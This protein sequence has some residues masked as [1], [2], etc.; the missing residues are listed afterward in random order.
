MKKY[1]VDATLARRRANWTRRP[2]FRPPI[3][4]LRTE[5]RALIRVLRIIRIR[6]EVRF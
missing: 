3:R 6:T 5:V 2:Y 4:V 1:C